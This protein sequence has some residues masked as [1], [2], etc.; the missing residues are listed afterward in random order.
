VEPAVVALHAIAAGSEQAGAPVDMPADLR[1]PAAGAEIRG[2][3]FSI[4]KTVE[5]RASL[6]TTMP[7]PPGS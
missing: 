6:A 4:R 1:E 7:I 3:V 2:E 5:S